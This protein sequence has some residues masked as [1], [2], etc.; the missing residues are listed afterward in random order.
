M[1]LGLGYPTVRTR[2]GELTGLDISIT[3]EDILI[4]SLP[5]QSMAIASGHPLASQ[6]AS[7]YKVVR[8]KD[9]PSAVIG[10]LGLSFQ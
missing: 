2:Y 6:M 5:T 8:A 7:P 4:V 1:N 9:N 3:S 10:C